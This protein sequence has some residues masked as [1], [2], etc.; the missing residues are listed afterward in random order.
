MNQNQKQMSET[1]SI[2]YD[3]KMKI[4]KFAFLKFETEESQKRE[5]WKPNSLVLNQYYKCIA[6]IILNFAAHK[7]LCNSKKDAIFRFGRFITFLAFYVQNKLFKT[8]D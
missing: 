2:L 7:S 3:K 8:G 5:N 6:E 4:L 1:C